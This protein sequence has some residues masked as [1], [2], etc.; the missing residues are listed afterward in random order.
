MEDEEEGA[1]IL[2]MRLI[3]QNNRLKEELEHHGY[4]QSDFARLISM[5]EQDLSGIINLHILPTED[6]MISIAIALEKPIDF[7][8]PDVLL[9]SVRKNIFKNRTRLLN[10]EE[11]KQI[12]GPPLLLL[13][14][15]GIQD[16]EEGLY[17]EAL[18]KQLNKAM[19]CLTHRERRVLELLYGLTGNP[20]L[21]LRKT[22]AEFNV[23][24]ERVRQI[25]AKALHK[26]R[27]HKHSRPLRE[28]MP[29]EQRPFPRKLN[30]NK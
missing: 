9:E 27:Y 18:D 16:V 26:L 1:K 21:D 11:V 10:G 15:G 14:S 28:F 8:F 20:P 6:Q 25:A 4:K 5:R 12:S 23:T 19:S 22:G 30:T 17:L 7:L 3:V 13:T 24:G 29:G 2:R